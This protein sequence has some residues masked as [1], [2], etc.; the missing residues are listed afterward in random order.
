MKIVTPE[1]IAKEKV[2]KWIKS[3]QARTNR[4]QTD[5]ANVLHTNQSAISQRLKAGTI[6]G[7]EL[8]LLSQKLGFDLSRL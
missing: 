6:K 2:T 3:E 8:I 1:Q 7:Y 4:N 5:I